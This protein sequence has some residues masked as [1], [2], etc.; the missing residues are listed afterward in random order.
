MAGWHE[1]TL[2]Y[3][4]R[5]TLGRCAF[6]LQA[7]SSLCVHGIRLRVLE[8]VEPFQRAMFRLIVPLRGIAGQPS[9]RNNRNHPH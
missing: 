2:P 3:D 6:G 1:T 4:A 9:S 7:Q 8:R 5:N